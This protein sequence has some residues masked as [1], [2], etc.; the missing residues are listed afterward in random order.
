MS[1][2]TTSLTALCVLCILAVSSVGAQSVEPFQFPQ[3]PVYGYVRTD[4]SNTDSGSVF[5]LMRFSQ[6][7]G[8]NSYTV[9]DSV[10]ALSAP[11]MCD[12]NAVSF[13]AFY[14]P[15]SSMLVVAYLGQTVKLDT[16]LVYVEEDLRAKT[17]FRSTGKYVHNLGRYVFSVRDSSLLWI[18]HIPRR[19]FLSI[20]Y[21]GPGNAYEFLTMPCEVRSLALTGDFSEALFAIQ[22]SLPFMDRYMDGA[23]EVCSFEFSSKSLL[24]A[25]KVLCEFGQTRRRSQGGPLYGVCTSG[26]Y[27]DSLVFSLS[28]VEDSVPKPLL[29]FEWPVSIRTYYLYPDS[30][31]VK[32]GKCGDKDYGVKSHVIHE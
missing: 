22:P 19:E 32:T 14:R 29:T 25:E 3:N 10:V 11:Q 2:K 17:V 26:D 23:T 4:S 6:T 18:P 5:Y 21:I 1:L 9:L 27:S 31:V 15:D 16:V 28:V 20:G 8:D 30:I 13:R 24:P 12:T 7:P